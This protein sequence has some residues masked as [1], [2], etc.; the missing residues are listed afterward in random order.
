MSQQYLLDPIPCD[1]YDLLSKEEIVDLHIGEQRIRLALQKEIEELKK[2]RDQAE[3]KSLLIEG[4]YVLIK[5]KLF[6][7]SS[8]KSSKF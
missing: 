4:N 7:K 3:Q 5:K 1:K 2:Q 8:E 6:G